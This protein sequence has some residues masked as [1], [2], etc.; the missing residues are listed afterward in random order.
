M[1]ETA[2]LTVK[3]N[4]KGFGLRKEVR[5]EVKTVYNST[6]ID[7]IKA[8]GFSKKFG[9]MTIHLAQEFGFCY[10]VDRA[11]E[12]AYET[13]KNF[14]NKKI[15]LTTEI[16]HNPT[17][18]QDLASLGIAFLSGPLKSA[19]ITDIK[20]EDV[21]LVPAFGTTTT[22]L[23]RL[24]NTGCTLVDTICGS[25]IVVW[26]RVEKY[27]KEGFTSIIHGKYYHEETLATSSQVLQYPGGH[28]LIVF[29]KKEAE[30][31]CAYIMNGGDRAAFL[32]KFKLA[33]S[34]GFDPDKH[35]DRVGL[36][37]QTTM[38]ASESLQI[39]DMVKEAIAKK[40]GTEAIDNHFCSFDTIC[41]ATQER[42][43]A[44][45]SLS[46]KK[47]DVFLVVGGYNSSN[48]GHL[49]KMASQFAASYHI[50]EA[51]CIVDAHA[52]RHKP[53]GKGAEI[54]STFW[55]P[56]GEVSLG[57]TSGASTPNN[58]MGEVVER[59]VTLIND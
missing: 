17:V 2:T 15:Y 46:Q 11:V 5:E 34:P 33:L 57:I 37:N 21:V 10:G 4:R 35:L 31:V 55:L 49:H 7:D 59:L 12:L 53:Y 43:D 20:R 48:T 14:P 18:N 23:Q 41:S 8:R 40:F 25:V 6:I 27:A 32:E 38:L 1:S 39:A 54:T 9:R 42:Q 50:N 44:I 22:E 30:T 56:K 28:Y 26:K 13:R 45:V 29:D 47:P 36:A 51:R 52:I 58:V 19:N 24:H 3:M 16:I